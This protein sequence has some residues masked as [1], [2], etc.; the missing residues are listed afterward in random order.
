MCDVC[1]SHVRSQP[2]LMITHI[3][4]SIKA[5]HVNIRILKRK[6]IKKFKNMAYKQYIYA[7]DVTLHFFKKLPIL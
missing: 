7:I 3:S 5:L 2:L 4:L 6:N 1:F